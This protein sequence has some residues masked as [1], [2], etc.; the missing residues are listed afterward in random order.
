MTQ[1]SRRF[2]TAEWRWLVMLNY[3]V[4]PK[5]VAPFVPAGTELDFH[6]DRTYLSVVGFQF[7]NTKIFGI[8]VPWHRNFEEV[9]LRLY[10][11]RQVDDELRR[12]V[13]FI[14]ELAPKRAVV[15][16]ANTLYNENYEW[17]QMRHVVEI[18]QP[19][20]SV[21]Y[22]WRVGQQWN[23]VRAEATGESSPLVPQS[24]EEFI[25]EHY[26]GYT[27]LRDGRTTEYR[28]DHPP[29]KVWQVS[30][31]RLD[32]DIAAVYGDPLV[33]ILEA[34]PDSAFIADGSEIA[35]YRPVTFTAT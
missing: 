35:V 22:E 15:T 32:C 29:W 33:P 24:L 17:R 27:A 26:W 23:G 14:K 7:W 12:G 3:E 9:N 1:H 20:P 16:I 19:A 25:A 31:A 5:L 21:H 6:F 34:P 11:K 28:V 10:V 4:D 2:L 8:P 18:D 13:V 30:N